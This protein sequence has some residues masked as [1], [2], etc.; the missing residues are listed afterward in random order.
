MNFSARELWVKDS[1]HVLLAHL[2]ADKAFLMLIPHVAEEFVRTE[3]RFMTKLL[4]ISS[5]L[6]QHRT[7][8]RHSPRKQGGERP[9]I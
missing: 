9:T 8:A 6:V 7:R 4:A 5:L 1:L 2:L 3:E